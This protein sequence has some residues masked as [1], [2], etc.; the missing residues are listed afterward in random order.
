MSTQ[1][2]S[3]VSL[4]RMQFKEA[5]GFLEGTLQGV[6]QEHAHWTPPGMANPLGATYAHIVL[7]EDGIIGGVLKGGAPLL[8][9]RMRCGPCR[10]TPV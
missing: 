9:T 10:W 3:A 6:S 2:D 5:H 7:T 4:F 1:I 8:A